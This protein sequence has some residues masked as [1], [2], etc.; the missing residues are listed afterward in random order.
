MKNFWKPLLVLA[1]FLFMQAFGGLFMGTLANLL[2]I[3]NTEDGAPN[4]FVLSSAII[5]SGILTLLVCWLCWHVIEMKRAITPRGIGLGAICLGLVASICGIVGQDLLA[6]IADLPNTI[7]ELMMSMANSL[8]GALGI[9]VIGPVV[10][11]FVFREGICGWMLRRGSNA[12]VAIITSAL[13]FGVAHLNPAQIAFASAMGIVLGI[14]YYKT[15]NILLCSLVHIINNSVAVIQIRVMGE[16]ARDFSFVDSVGGMTN[17]WVIIVV[18]T[19]LCA[20]LL[21]KFLKLRTT[22]EYVSCCDTDTPAE[23]PE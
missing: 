9:A 23:L 13:L 17:A 22:P 21:W 15:G 4:M 7:E 5:L 3:G 19:L 8:W 6:E 14:L 12:A 16:A 20:A 10:E 1:T 2:N 18:S 11:E